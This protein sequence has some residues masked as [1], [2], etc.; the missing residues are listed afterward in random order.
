MTRGKLPKA[1]VSNGLLANTSRWQVILTLATLPVHLPT[2]CGATGGGCSVGAHFP[3]G[4]GVGW[5][6]RGSQAGDFLGGS[7]LSGLLWI[8]FGLHAV[9]ILA[10]L[11]AAYWMRGLHVDDAMRVVP[12]PADV[13]VADAPSLRVYVAAHNEQD[14]IEACLE[15]LLTQNY[16]PLRVTVVNDRSDDSTAARVRGVMDHESRVDLVEVTELPAGWIGKTHALAKATTG[17]DADYLLFVDCDCRLVPG[18]IAG[19]MSKVTGESLD[20]LSLWPRLVLESAAEKLLT[21][22]VCWLLGLWT[23]AAARSESGRSQA[24]LGNGQFVLFSR[25]AYERIGGHA[26]ARAELAED[27]VMARRVE[28]LGLSRWAGWGEGLYV[29]S[30]SNGF[31]A[32]ANAATRVVIG[33][34]TAPVR[35]FAGANLV[36]GG[37]GAPLN[38][39]VPALALVLWTALPPWPLWG[40]VALAAAQLLLMGFTLP[41]MFERVFKPVPSVLHFALGGQVCTFILLRASRVIAGKGSVRWGKTRYRV[42]GSQIVETLPSES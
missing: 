26:A 7:S 1:G 36:A 3:P 18:A 22:P 17:A 37:L 2:A 21:P 38:L 11:A 10:W 41:R 31:K 39:G 6:V 25:D 34:L 23:L 4:V 32:A 30:R 24:V 33:S 29:S 20:Y 9:I 27:V 13:S 28:S 42:K 40:I 12:K 5:S 16:E 19:V 14:R 8:I 35:V 15:R